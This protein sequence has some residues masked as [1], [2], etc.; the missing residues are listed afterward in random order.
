MAL[1]EKPE[2]PVDSC[3]CRALRKRLAK[4][5]RK[6]EE[7]EMHIKQLQDAILKISSGVVPLG[8]GVPVQ[9]GSRPSGDQSRPVFVG[10]SCFITT[11][12]TQ[13]PVP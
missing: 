9:T 4:S 13:A 8:E 12:M 5:E 2:T 10:P 11:M 7:M 6:L 1:D 3:S